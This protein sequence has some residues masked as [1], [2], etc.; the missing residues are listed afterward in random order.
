MWKQELEELRGATTAPVYQTAAVMQCPG[1]SDIMLSTLQSH[2][3]LTVP[4][5]S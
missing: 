5:L 2:N 1:Y 3:T 4:L